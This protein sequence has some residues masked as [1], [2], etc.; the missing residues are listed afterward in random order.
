LA[1]VV[2][3]VPVMMLIGRKVMAFKAD[4]SVTPLDRAALV[5]Q[6][7][8][9]KLEG[10][11]FELKEKDGVLIVAPPVLTTEI[12]MG[13][14]HR[15]V[16]ETF[17]VKIWLD[18]E[19]RQVSLKDIVTTRTEMRGAGE[20]F[21]QIHGQSGFVTSS[22]LIVD[23]SGKVTKLGNGALRKALI[24]MFNQSGWNVSFK[25]F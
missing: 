7:R 24:E 21:F 13:M 25:I 18:E 19:K 9:F 2:G 14:Q 8:E 20:Y 6:L 15:N 4:P 23:G 3:M 10:S 16:E 12:T 5:E 22:T 17:F 1:G 11:P